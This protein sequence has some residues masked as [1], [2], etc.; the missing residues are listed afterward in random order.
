MVAAMLARVQLPA[1]VAVHWLLVLGLGLVFVGLLG[2][3]LAR[4]RDG[5]T[6]VVGMAS[7]VLGLGLLA[8]P[9]TGVLRGAA[10]GAGIGVLGVLPRLLRD[11]ARAER[12]MRR[13]DVMVEE[14]RAR[15]G[16]RY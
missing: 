13:E 10:M 7:V 12:L 15:G 8:W 5:G 2:L 6:V 1:L 14:E 3:T 4:D 9:A 11:T 16:R